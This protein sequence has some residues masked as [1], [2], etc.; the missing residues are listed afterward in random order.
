VVF[1]YQ[2]WV[3]VGGKNRLRMFE[4]EVLRRI[5]WSKRAEA[6]W[7]CRKFNTEI[8]NLYLLF[9]DVGW[10]EVAQNK[11]KQMAF[12]NTI[13]NLGLHKRREMFT[14]TATISFSRITLLHI[15]MFFFPQGGNRLLHGIHIKFFIG[16]IILCK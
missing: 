13:I 1:G 4:N 14:S 12:M 16:L 5:F 7:G 9:E 3:T 15:H 6:T 10:I 2:N 11:I 8:S